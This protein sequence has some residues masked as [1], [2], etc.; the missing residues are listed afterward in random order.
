MRVS[1][2]ALCPNCTGAPGAAGTAAP[3][4]APVAAWVLAEASCVVDC[5]AAGPG[6][7]GGAGRGE[8][9]AA[10]LSAGGAGTDVRAPGA[11]DGGGG[12]SGADGGGESGEYTPKGET[13]PIDGK[14]LTLRR[15]LCVGVKVPD[16]TEVGVGVTGD[17]TDG[18]CPAAAAGGAGS[19][20]GGGGTYPGVAT[21]I[22][23]TM[24][25]VSLKSLAA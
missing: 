13:V 12:G 3:A 16:D 25:R 17:A 20:G 4:G 9:K 2:V 11:A 23:S 14:G 10:G 6:G 18:G 19:G 1:S 21:R 7:G 15:K 22:V 8:A 24:R 5:G